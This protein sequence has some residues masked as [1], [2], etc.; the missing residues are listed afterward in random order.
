MR[1]GRI[2]IIGGVGWLGGAIGRA[3]LESGYLAPAD[4]WLQGEAAAEAG[5]TRGSHAGRS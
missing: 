2:G 5:A 3:L 1:E 4:L